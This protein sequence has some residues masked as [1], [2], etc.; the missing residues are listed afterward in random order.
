MARYLRTM[1][2]ELVQLA[3]LHG[4]SVL[5]DHLKA[6]IRQ[7]GSAKLTAVTLRMVE[8]AAQLAV[9]TPA[10]A[11]GVGQ[12]FRPLIARQL[13]A[14]GAAHRCAA[15]ENARRMAAPA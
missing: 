14:I 15:R 10:L 4:S 11:H 5:A 13:V 6:S 8:Q 1:R 2:D 7:H 3:L 9:A 12:W